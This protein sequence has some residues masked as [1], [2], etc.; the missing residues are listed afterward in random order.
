[1]TVYATLLGSPDRGERNA[2]LAKLLDWGFSRYRAA[3]V[4]TQGA[5]STRRAVVGYGRE[6]V[7]LVAAASLRPSLRVD[8]P[9]VRRV[10]AM[11]TAELPVS[12]G[13]SLGQVRIYQ[14]GKLVG[15]V[16][17]VASRSVSR[18]GRR[19]PRR[20]VRGTY[21]G[22]H[23]GLGLVI[24]TVTM[25]AAI[26]RTLTV[27]NFQRGQRHRASA[28]LTLAGGKGINIARALKRLGV[29]VVATGLAGGRT[30]TRIVEE[31]TA[32]AI[33]NDFVRIDD[34]SR[35]ST[36][37]VD[38]T[39]GSYTEV[40]EWGPHVSAE[41]L[42]ML[43]EKLVYLSQGADYVVFSGSLPRG[44]DDG[45][46]AEAVRELNRRGAQTV[47]DSEG[48]PLRLGVQAEPLLVSPN[49]REAEALVGQEFNDDD[50]FL[51]GLETIAELGAR[52][53][54][55]TRESGC[56]AL[57]RSRAGG[58]PLPRR[59]AAGRPGLGGR[60]RRRA[61]RRLRR[62][63]ARRPLRRGGAACR[64]RGRG[65]L[66]ARDRR[67]QV[68][69]ARGRPPDRLGRSGA[70]RARRQLKPLPAAA[71]TCRAMKRQRLPVVL[72]AAA[73]VVAVLSATPNGIAGSAVRVALFA[74][75]AA[76]VS[77]IAASKKPKAG[78]L[79]PLGKNGKFP[80]SVLP[81]KVQGPM[82]PAGAEGA[83]GPAGSVG[84]QG[85]Q[86]IQGL[87]GFKGVTGPA[88]PQ[89][90][91][92]AQGS[93][94]PPGGFGLLNLGRATVSRVSLDAGGAHSSSTAGP[95]GFPLVAVFDDSSKSLVA[96]HCNDAACSSKSQHHRRR[97]GP[98]VGRHP[99]VTIGSDG[100]G[101]VSYV[102]ATNGNLKAA[103]CTNLAC[104]ASTT[105]AIVSS[106]TVV[107]DYTSATV[108]LDGLGADRVRGQRPAPRR[109]LLEPRL[110]GRDLEPD[111]LDRD[112][113][114]LAGDRRRRPPAGQLLRQRERRPQGRPLRR[115]ALCERQ[116]HDPRQ[117][118]HR[119]PLHLTDGRL[120]RARPDQLPQRRRRPGRRP[121]LQ[122]RLL[123]GDDA[124]H[125]RRDQ[126][127][128][129]G[130]HARASTASA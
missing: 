76:K 98:D 6:P 89:G 68:R 16:P 97:L 116:R 42:E 63:A 67:G 3:S 54:L 85:A 113:L 27:P 9:L 57:L 112:R 1:M 77:G 11:D 91:T 48:E 106:G 100:L 60:L 36:A 39:G 126:G 18:P 124:D 120:R 55:I 65:R 70:A 119:R 38:P 26:D 95:D 44:I 69:A 114:R 14:R 86:G 5:T 23:V 46:Y 81:V 80:A 29:P 59:R 84:P 99:S 92:G 33:L 111:R 105:A 78:K 96:V 93:V 52:N 71:D 102:D 122:P 83:R 47:L 40:N 58:D 82:G 79:L 32:E 110:L 121:L 34:E 61:A 115:R 73:L 94:G 20:L 130:D 108:G 10:V 117:H 25:N 49:E 123:G 51:I 103:H 28:G 15:A 31:L 74:K 66:D 2:D 35:T 104:T 22:P 12:R 72:S 118:R 88:G 62:G 50:D 128:V 19:G 107:Q 21:P 41:E 43:L 8:F 53:V 4:V 90:T 24:V 37:I 7:A 101:L 129:L 87:R 45:F 30:G 17:L 13:Q 64:G 109:A 56:W 75:N 125:R 127:R